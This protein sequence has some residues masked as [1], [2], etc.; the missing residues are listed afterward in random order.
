MVGVKSEF[1]FIGRVGK[2]SWNGQCNVLLA[3][4]LVGDSCVM[5]LVEDAQVNDVNDVS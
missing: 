3:A 5:L 2:Y 4:A 1:N